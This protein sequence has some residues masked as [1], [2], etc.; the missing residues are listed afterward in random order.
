MIKEL[1]S[2]VEDKF[3][4]SDNFN[5]LPVYKLKSNFDIYNKD[6]KSSI[7]KAITDE[8][9]T[10]RFDGIPHIIAFS[11]IPKNKILQL[12]D[13]SEYPGYIC[14]FPHNTKL[15]N[16]KR[17]SQYSSMP[18]K[19]ELAKGAGQLECRAFEL[20]VIEYYRN[21]PRYLYN[22]DTINGKI[23][24]IEK[25][26]CTGTCPSLDQV[27][28]QTFG[29]AYDN[30]QNKYITVFLRDLANLNKQHQNAWA[31]KEIK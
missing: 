31:E 29:Y 26:H 16:S 2:I 24:I 25:Q 23:R 4:S 30:N 6:F 15:L 12:F 7:M 14:L 9:L 20:S 1:Y 28:L 18:Y 3:F 19:L 21:N 8:I 13:K 22:T 11:N 17:L 5:G 10:A 27:L